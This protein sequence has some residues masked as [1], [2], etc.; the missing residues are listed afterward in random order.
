MKSNRRESV[1]AKCPFY[2]GEEAQKVICE[3]VVENSGIH[4]CFETP[5]SQKNY[6]K[7]H[8]YDCYKNCVIYKALCGKYEE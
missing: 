4:L 1:S 3:G 6:K 5:T 7:E 2:E 8:C